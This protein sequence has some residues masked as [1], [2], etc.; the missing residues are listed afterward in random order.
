MLMPTGAMRPFIDR[1]F[2]VSDVPSSSANS[3]G[4]IRKFS[5]IVTRAAAP[6]SRANSTP[7]RGG[8]MASKA[9]ATS[10]TGVDEPA[11][12]INSARQR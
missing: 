11:M 3:S 7:E 10:S 12:L 4:A 5:A 1:R 8:S 2:P 6:M 9:M